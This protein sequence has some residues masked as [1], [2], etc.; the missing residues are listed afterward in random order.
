MTPDDEML[1]AYADGELDPIT[2]KRVERAI[3]NDA[4]LADRVR[5][6]RRLRAMVGGAFAGVADEPV[7][8]RLASLVRGS[9]VPFPGPRRTAIRWPQVAAV[10]AALALGVG[11]GSQIDGRGS[12]VT[13]G[14]T[15]VASGGLARALDGQLASTKGETRVP[16]SFRD[17]RGR[18]CRV[19]DAPTT[20]GIACRQGNAWTLVRTRSGETAGAATEYRQ[21]GSADAALLADAQDLMAGDPLDAAA[22]VRA[23]EAGWR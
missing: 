7:P 20:D 9:V 10:A 22:E 15:L 19:F 2:A 13:D 3:A 1:M 5:A 8:D 4:G 21:A 6:H 12:V 17:A 23:R 14:G 16:V 18:L 11:L